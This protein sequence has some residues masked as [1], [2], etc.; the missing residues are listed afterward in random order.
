MKRKLVKE[1]RLS[2]GSVLADQAE[3]TTRIEPKQ[4]IVLS[5]N[6]EGRKI[7][8]RTYIY[9][10]ETGLRPAV[11]SFDQLWGITERARLPQKIERTGYLALQSTYGQ[12]KSLT[13]RWLFDS[14]MGP[15][16]GIS[17]SRELKYGDEIDDAMTWLQKPHLATKE[18]GR[19]ATLLPEE[20]AILLE[21]DEHYIMA[22]EQIIAQQELEGRANNIIHKILI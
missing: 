19:I 16:Y 2:I 9:V 1:F 15:S 13:R 17:T 7:D 6:T 8:N 21:L 10:G 12:N 3:Q 22:N 14:P 11:F 20:E 4:R 18:I 5:G